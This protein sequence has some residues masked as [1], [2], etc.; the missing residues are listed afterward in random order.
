MYFRL[1]HLFLLP[2][3]CTQVCAQQTSTKNPAPAVG[4]SRRELSDTSAESQRLP[5]SPPDDLPGVVNARSSEGSPKSV[6]TSEEW[7]KVDKAV[8]R[9]LAWLATQQRADGSYPTLDYGQ[10][11]VTSFC[12]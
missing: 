8:S 12:T 5:A 9:A 1:I 4:L 3:L 2:L 7:S 10:P 6:L 11:A